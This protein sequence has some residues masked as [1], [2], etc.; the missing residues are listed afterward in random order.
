MALKLARAINPSPAMLVISNPK[1]VSKRMATKAKAKRE[2]T[3]KKP[4]KAAAVKRSNP[5]AQYKPKKATAKPKRKP[6]KRNP[7]LTTGLGATAVTAF[8]TVLAMTGLGLVS[9][10]VPQLLGASPAGRAVQIGGLGWLGGY[11]AKRLGFPKAG[12]SIQLAGAVLG[13]SIAIEAYVAP[14][15]R[16][17][18]QPAPQ[19]AP[20]KVNVKQMGDLVTLP[21]GSY[22]DYYGTTPN[23]SEFAQPGGLGDLVSMRMYPG[24][25]Q[26]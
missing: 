15:I 5:V 10:M 25:A 16:G 14:M 26:Y 2:T 18:L 23:F 20:Q 8:N 4:A 13:A 12:E 17:A 7:S 6:V 3:A 1:G 22:D 21:A 9:P 19:P 24:A 11:A